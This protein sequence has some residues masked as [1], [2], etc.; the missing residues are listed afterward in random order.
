MVVIHRAVKIY[1]NGAYAC[2]VK[3]ADDKSTTSKKIGLTLRQ[4]DTNDWVAFD[5]VYV[6]YTE[7]N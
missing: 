7:V 6:G 3:S 2:T 5:N 4:F 1:V